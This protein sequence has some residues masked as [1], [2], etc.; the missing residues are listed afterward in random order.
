V[1]VSLLEKLRA[2]HIPPRAPSPSE[3]V[4]RE[5]GPSQCLPWRL[6]LPDRAAAG[7]ITPHMSSVAMRSGALARL[8]A[9]PINR[10]LVATGAGIGWIVVLGRIFYYNPMTYNKTSVWDMW[11]YNFIRPWMIKFPSDG[12]LMKLKELLPEPPLKKGQKRRIARD[13]DAFYRVWKSCKGSG[14]FY[15][16][17]RS[18]GAFFWLM[19]P[20]WCFS[21]MLQLPRKFVQFLPPLLVSNLLD[22]LQDPKASMVIGYKLMLLAALRMICDKFGES[23]VRFR[24]RCCRHCCSCCCP[25]HLQAV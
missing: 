25:P 19:L 11:S 5:K 12:P 20:W 16:K 21:H 14:R 4:V 15:R 24:H 1:E 17:G 8:L 9:D 18:S 13:T 22:F 10:Y 7:A 3:S 2:E 6:R 23:L